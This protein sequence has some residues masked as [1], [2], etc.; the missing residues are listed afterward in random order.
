AGGGFSEYERRQPA[1]P[2]SWES[3]VLV[4]LAQSAVWGAVGGLLSIGLPVFITGWPWWTPFP[5]FVLSTSLAWWLISADHQRALW[6]VEKMVNR[7]LDGDGQ[8][9]QPETD[10]PKSVSLEVTH[11]TEAGTFVRMF[12]FDLHPSITESLFQQWG[13]QA[14]KNGDLTQALWVN[15][16]SFSREA[17]TDLLDK[18]ESSGLVQRSGSAKNA[19]YELTRTGQATIRRYLLT[20]HSHSLTQA[21]EEID[22]T[23]AGQGSL[24]GGH[25]QH[26]NT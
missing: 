6:I 10:A 1:R 21:D 2:A 17:Y 26:I 24:T 5:A 15:R 16:R 25:Y 23:S 8:T 20:T 9:G 12:R 13:R 14:L 19:P 3:D 22:P 11:R 18:L 4:P 7:D